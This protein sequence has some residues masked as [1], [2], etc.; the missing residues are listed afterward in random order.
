MHKLSAVGNACLLK[1]LTPN[2][3]TIARRTC[4]TDAPKKPYITKIHWWSIMGNWIILC[5]CIQNQSGD[6]P[7]L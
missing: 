1:R 4:D 3:L 7:G 6:L 5:R 2:K